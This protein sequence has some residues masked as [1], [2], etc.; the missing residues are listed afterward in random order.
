MGRDKASLP[1][2]GSTLLSHVVTVLSRVV[3]EIVVVSRA[4]QVLPGLGPLPEGVLLTHAYDEREH[5]GPLGGLAPGLSAL[6][7]PI[8]YVSACDV[9][10]LAE[11]FVRAMFEALGEAALAV[12][13][14]EGRPHPL[15]A[16]YRR[17]LVLPEIA[18]LLAR[19]RRRAADLLERLPHVLVEEARL[20]EVDPSLD[21]LA[22]LNTPEAYAAALARG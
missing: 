13:W 22:N 12:P 1:W 17:D 21:S 4:G 18:G 2:R 5:L 10:Y 19:D 8:A 15:A 16:V 3:D 7:A 6:S 14:A 11:A 9:P 20:R